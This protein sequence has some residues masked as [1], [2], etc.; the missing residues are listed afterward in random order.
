[1]ELGDAFGGGS[2]EVSVIDVDCGAGGSSKI[3]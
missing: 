1:V 2:Q 3:L